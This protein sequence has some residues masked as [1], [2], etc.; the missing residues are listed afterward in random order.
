MTE[1]SSPLQRYERDIASGALLPDAAQA[2]IVRDLNDLYFRLV[3]RAGRDAGVWAR[4][5]RTTC[6][7]QGAGV[8]LL[9]M[10]WRRAMRLI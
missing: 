3:Q 9:W 2:A 4:A 8:W 10:A 7:L 5:Q 6:L 1:Q